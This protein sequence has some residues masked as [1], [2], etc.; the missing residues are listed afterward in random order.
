MGNFWHPWVKPRAV[1]QRRRTL[2]TSTEQTWNVSV[3]FA[4]REP[5]RSALYTLATT[6]QFL[7]AFRMQSLLDLPD[8]EQMVDAGLAG[9]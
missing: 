1:E 9:S 4:Q 3:T 8:T 5:S 2:P 7:A 6:S